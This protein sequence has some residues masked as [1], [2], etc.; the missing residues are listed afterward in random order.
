MRR[1][2]K[3]LALSFVLAGCQLPF[4]AR[5]VSPSAEEPAEAQLSASQ[6][7]D[8][9]MAFAQAFERQGEVESAAQAYD[10]VIAADPKRVDA[11]VRRAIL[12]DQQGKFTESEK[13]YKRALDRRPKDANLFCNIGYS[14]YLQH[15]WEEAEQCLR[16]AIA[17]KADHKRAHNNLGLVLARAGRDEEALKEFQMGGCP[18]ADAHCNLAYA[19]IM[20][21]SFDEAARQYEVALAAQPNC[22]A[23]REGLASLRVLVVREQSG[24]N[25]PAAVHQAAVKAQ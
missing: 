23:A 21:Q 18:K 16:K 19:H 14:L 20:N 4:Q 12:A 9:Q 7:A 8:M 2:S 24:T 13:Y 17:L 25:Q 1:L 5:S 11:V 6:K 15:R 3:V 22:A 10:A